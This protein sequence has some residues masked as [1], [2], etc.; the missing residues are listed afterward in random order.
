MKCLN[1]LTV[2][3]KCEILLTITE[4][5]NLRDYGAEYSSTVTLTVM[6]EKFEFLLRKFADV[7]DCAQW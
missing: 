7:T 4:G 6:A 2:C 1:P 5:N 3:I